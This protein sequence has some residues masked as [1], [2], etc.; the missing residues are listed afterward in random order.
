[1]YLPSL[2]TKLFDQICKREK[3]P[4]AVVGTVTGDGKVVVYDE[5]D[6]STPVNL[7]LEKV[8]GKMP[9]KTFHSQTLRKELSPFSLPQSITI[10]ECLERVLKLVSVGSKLFLTNK[11]Y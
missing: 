2:T 4:Y 1:M 3:L 11:V 6:D 10:K 8:L 7:E 5:K 9:P